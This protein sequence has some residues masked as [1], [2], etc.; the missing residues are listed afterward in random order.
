MDT[1]IQNK[2]DARFAQEVGAKATD[3]EKQKLILQ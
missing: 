1:I 3:L 2:L